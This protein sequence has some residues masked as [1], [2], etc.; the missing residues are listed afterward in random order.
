MRLDKVHSVYFLGIGGIGMSALA[1]WFKRNGYFVAGYDR[2]ATTLTEKLEEEGIE[3]HFD[4]T[5]E[6]IP[7]K[8]LNNKDETLIVYTPAI[9]KDHVEYNYLQEQG[10]TIMKRSQVLGVLTKDLYTIA[11]AGT[12][13][14]TTTS[15]MIAHIFKT[16][17]ENCSAFL[18]GIATNL[19]SNLL[20]N[21]H[22]GDDIKVVVEAD[23]FDRSFLTLYPN[24]AVVTSADADHLDIYGD[25]D[26]LNESF[27]AFIERIAENGTLFINEKIAADLT[28]DKDPFNVVTYSLDS[29]DIKAKN[30][31]IKDACFVFDLISENYVI[32][33]L[34][35][36]VPGYHNVENAVAS[37]AVAMQVGIDQESIKT[38]IETYAGVSRR[39]EYIIKEKDLIYI[40]DYAH[41]P[42]EI[43]AFLKSVKSLYPQK[44][45]T[46]V[47]QPHLFT[48]TRDFASGFA[49]S[50][51]LA[52]EVYLM[53]IY[54]ARELPIEGVSSDMIFKKIEIKNKYRCNKQNVLKKLEESQLEVLVTIGAGDIDCFVEPIKELLN[55]KY[56]EV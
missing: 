53:D 20:M 6:M 2:T 14:K 41:H 45:L 1:R 25:K 15:S 37:I 49:K 43:E 52:D 50:L 17:Q 40:D 35:L 9:P 3:I 34:K 56:H 48:R 27:R 23:E 26:H 46:A 36:S 18:G 51:G 31:K 12:H 32:H 8:V 38:A 13:G 7:E 39:F 11:V 44:K 47:F 28:G 19:G 4:D 21:E 33:D 54:P 22:E 29:G 42:V 16:A 30:I 5:L 10:Y 24:I 55:K